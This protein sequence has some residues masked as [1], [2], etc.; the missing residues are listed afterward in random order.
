MSSGSM[1]TIDSLTQKGVPMSQV[2]TETRYPRRVARPPWTPD[3]E[4]ANLLATLKAAAEAREKAE[5]TYRDALAKCA[6]A[7]VPVKVLAEQLKVE[8][9][10]VYRHLGRSMT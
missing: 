1:Y 6:A 3:A 2:G 9:K 5:A 4:Q 10:T 7:D 8:R